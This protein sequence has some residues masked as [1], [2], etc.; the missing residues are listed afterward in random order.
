MENASFETKKEGHFVPQKTLNHLTQVEPVI[1]CLKK[2]LYDFLRSFLNLRRFRCF[3][4]IA[5]IQFEPWMIIFRFFFELFFRKTNLM[6][7]K[8]LPFIQTRDDRLNLLFCV[9]TGTTMLLGFL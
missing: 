8:P 6:R 1:F 2:Q 9:S 4:K 7:N 3:L 5:G